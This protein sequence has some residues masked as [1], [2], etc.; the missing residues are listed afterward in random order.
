MKKGDRVCVALSNI[1]EIVYSFFAVAKIGGIVAWA[2]PGYREEELNFIL[3]NS[4]AVAAIFHRE[5]KGFDY[6]KMLNEMRSDLPSL[7]HIIL[8]DPAGAANVYNLHELMQKHAG[9][10]Y[11]K[12]PINI[13]EDIVL[14]YNTGGTTGVPKAAAHTH[15]TA[16]MR[17]TNAIDL[18][19]ITADDVTLALLPI[20]HPFGGAVCMIL[21]IAT[22]HTIALMPEYNAEHALQLIE[23]ERVTIHH[24]AP[25]H[26]ILETKSPN[27]RKY[28][29]SSLRI[30]LGAGFAWPP[31]VF[32]R[33]K[34]EMGLDIV[35]MWGMAEIG[36]TGIVCTP[37]EGIERRNTHIGRPVE[38]EVKVVDPETGQEMG[39]NEPGE[40][41]FRGPIMKFYWNNP[42]ETAKSFDSEGWFHTGDLVVR[43]EEGY[44]RIVG[45]AKEQINRGGLKIVPNELEA[46]LIKHPKV[47]EVCVI[48]TPN[49]VLGE[50]I[51]ACVVPT[52]DG[53]P[54]L[55]ELRDFLKDKIA[56]YKLPEE[57]CIMESFPRLA[58]GV[59]YR[60]FGPGSIQEMAVNDEGRERFRK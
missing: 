11:E 37:E 12:P 50:S 60:K 32:M 52:D 16:V 20:Y 23:K 1:P 4:G 9:E 13:Y 42:Q 36:G 44:I 49:P 22:Q 54:T 48:S 14:F 41:C 30:G 59:K 26:I 55:Q 10:S 3:R 33:A 19:K 51:C 2:N 17:A 27:F 18:L 5:L 31:E 57:L 7:Q 29:L 47:K 39:P 21:P 28:D 6:L 8:V 25:T 34:E 45:R 38:G 58:G 35:H 46:L 40:M 53:K 43:D 24:A 15:Y 56:A